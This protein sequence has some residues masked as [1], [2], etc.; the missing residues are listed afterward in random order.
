[1][2]RLILG[3]RGSKLALMQSQWVADSIEAE[4]G[5]S[6]ELQV[7]ETRGDKIIDNQ[8]INVKNIPLLLK[9]ESKKE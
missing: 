8:D 6:V 7:I 9:K 4:T 3:T 1:M 5:V 2:K